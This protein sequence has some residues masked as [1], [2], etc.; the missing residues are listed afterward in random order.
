[1]AR[2]VNEMRCLRGSDLITRGNESRTGSF[3][4]DIP[5]SRTELRSQFRASARTAH[6]RTHKCS[7][8]LFLGL[9]R[10][11]AP[12]TA[13]GVGEGI[14]LQVLA[15]CSGTSARIFMVCCRSAGRLVLNSKLLPTPGYIHLIV[16]HLI[17]SIGLQAC[18]CAVEGERPCEQ[19]AWTQNLAC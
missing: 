1:M 17:F 13:A 5:A 9:F 3:R 16:M 4:H 18:G 2:F 10:C 7:R 12:K 11:S 15:S 6:S 8:C 19:V 14:D